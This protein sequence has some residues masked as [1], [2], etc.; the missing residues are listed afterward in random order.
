MKCKPGV[1]VL[2]TPFCLGIP[3]LCRDELI[4]QFG[5][6]LAHVFQLLSLVLLLVLHLVFQHPVHHSCDGVSRR[7]RCLRRS[8]PGFQAPVRHKDTVRLLHRLRRQFSNQFDRNPR[9][10]AGLRLRASPL[11][12]TACMLAIPE[13]TFIN[14]ISCTGAAVSLTENDGP[15]SSWAHP[16]GGILRQSQAVFYASAFF[17]LDGFAVPTLVVEFVETQRR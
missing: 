3:A 5:C 16:T 9:C 2:R 12:C 4:A 6:L 15:P 11:L 8:Q 7:H 14:I 10:T 13:Y 1:L 17:W